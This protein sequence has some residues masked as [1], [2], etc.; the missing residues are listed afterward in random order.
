M[1]NDKFLLGYGT[2][3]HGSKVHLVDYDTNSMHALG[4]GEPDKALC[5]I[6]GD[7]TRADTSDEGGREPCTACDN[8]DWSHWEFEESL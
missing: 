8:A 4:A 1:T 6:V 5:G 7:F 3:E 2:T